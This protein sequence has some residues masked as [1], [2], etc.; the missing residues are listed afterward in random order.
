LLY[1]SLTPIHPWILFLLNSEQ[2]VQLL[3]QTSNALVTTVTTTTIPV[4]S[5]A[6]LNVNE[7]STTSI[8]F[9]PVVLCIIYLICKLNQLY[10]IL[11]ETISVIKELYGDM[12]KLAKLFSIY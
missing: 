10:N 4:D 1:R 11:N 9:F 7:L 6:K 2:N 12:V 5:V 3:K 8:T